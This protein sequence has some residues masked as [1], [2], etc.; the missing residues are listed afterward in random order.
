MLKRHFVTDPRLKHQEK[1][2]EEQHEIMSDNESDDEL[3]Y[4]EQTK[5]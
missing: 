4:E 5:V 1:S 2:M 3:E